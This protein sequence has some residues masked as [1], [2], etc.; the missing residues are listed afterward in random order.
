MEPEI[1]AK[2]PELEEFDSPFMIQNI[3][4]IEYLNNFQKPNFDKS[5]QNPDYKHILVM[6][7]QCEDYI[8]LIRK[9]KKKYGADLHL[10]Y[11]LLRLSQ[12][13]SRLRKLLKLADIS[14]DDIPFKTE[15]EVLK[16]LVRTEN[17]KDS[18]VEHLENNINLLAFQVTEHAGKTGE[19]YISH[20]RKEWWKMLVSAM[21]GGL[22]VGF[23]TIF[24]VIIYYLKLA[25]FGE[26]FLYSMNY[27]LVDP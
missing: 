5:D 10:T 22:I 3:E 8:A 14:N 26:T 11:L 19:H 2:L 18:L 21:G 17:K 9:E 15:I 6:L 13:I 24:K 16:T 23:L 1:L 12:N 27:S 20:T 7:S 25:S 4:I